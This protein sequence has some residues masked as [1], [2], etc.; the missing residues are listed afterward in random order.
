MKKA[1]SIILVLSLV[2]C[3]VACNQSE[4][5]PGKTENTPGK[6]ETTPGKTETKTN[7]PKKSDDDQLIIGFN[8]NSLTNETMTFMVDVFKQYGDEHNI[9]ILTSQDGGDTATML[10]NLENFVAGGVD[11]I[12]F[13]NYDKEGVAPLLE[14]LRAKGIAIV[15]YDEYSELCDY[16]FLCS[17]EELG[18]A[19]GTMAAEWAN[20]NLEG[21]V[22]VAL[23]G[24]DMNSFLKV[25]GDA[26]QKALEDNIPNCTVYR[27][28]L[29]Q[30]NDQVTI[31]SNL[32]AAHPGI[33]M[34][35]GIADACVVQAAEAWYGDLVG[36]G[37]DLSQYGVFAT[38]ATDI[39]LNLIKK[40]ENN[41]AIM[42]GTI[43]L[44]LKDVIPLGMITCC[45][46]AIE[47][48]DPGY[49]EVNYYNIKFVTVEN[50]DEYS[51]FID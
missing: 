50:I 41:E 48:R 29:G 21:P 46:A 4:G 45:H 8:T 32:T 24:V 25:R 34:L 19:I 13:M 17:N 11:G 51:E 3:L 23:I 44:G 10:T 6:T 2:F 15:S 14:D 12:I 7:D 37:A 49:P 35:V 18:T 22:E 30:G 20:E 16:S 26:L 33:R 5:T 42:R 28:N 31:I 39:A 38:D 36:A 43:D 27:E 1:L 9:K 40:S 47:G